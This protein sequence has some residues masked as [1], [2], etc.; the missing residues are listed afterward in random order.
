MVAAK[1]NDAPTAA[2]VAELF[3][4][5]DMTEEAITLY[6]KAIALAP[7]APQYREYLGEYYHTLKRSDDALKTWAE[8][9]SGPNRNAKNLSRLSEVLSGFGFL[10]PALKAAGEARELAPDD[11]NLRIKYAA[12]LHRA[13]RHAEALA[14]LDIADKLASDDDEFLAVVEQQIKNLMMLGQIGTASDQLKKELDAGQAASARRWVRLARYL[15]AAQRLPE[16]T[17][18]AR[19]ALEIDARSVPALATLA[20]TQENS[21]NLAASAETLRKLATIDR[22]A[23]TEYLTTITRLEARLGHRAEAL[24]AGRDLLAAAP[25]NPEHYEFFSDLC[26]QLGELEEGFRALQRAIRA[27]PG[28]PKILFT[29]AEALARQFRTEEAIELYWRAFDKAPD[30]DERLKAVNKLAELYLQD[31]QFDRM[32]A[33]LRRERSEPAQQRELAICLAQAY[34]A[35][36]DLGTARQELERLF[37]A[38]PKDTQLLEQLSKLSEEEGDFSTAAQYQRQLVEL[39]P[40]GLATD[41]LAQLYIQAGEIEEAQALWE[42]QTAGDHDLSRV[43]RALDGLLGHGKADAVLLITERLLRKHPDNW[44]L[45]YREGQA[46]AAKD[47]REAAAKRFRTLLN[48]NVEDDELGAIAKA[49][50]GRMGNQP[51]PANTAFQ[52]FMS[53]MVPMQSRVWASSQAAGVAGIGSRAGMASGSAWAPTDFGQARM[54]AIAFLFGFAQHENK[55]QEFV[56]K[57]REAGAKSGPDAR[58]RW[59]LFYLQMVRDRAREIFE[60]ARDLARGSPNDPSAQWAFLFYL[61]DRTTSPGRYNFRPTTIGEADHIPPLKEEDIDL[62]LSAYHTLSLHKPEWIRPEILVNVDIELRRAKR[63]DQ[64]EA[65]YREALARANDGPTLAS[66]LQLAAERGNVD[67]VL[68]LFDKADQRFVGYQ[69]Y[70]LYSSYAGEAE[71][72]AR[73]MNARAQVN[74]HEDIFKIC[75]H[76]LTVARHRDPM[77]RRR[78]TYGTNPFIYGPPRYMIWLGKNYRFKAI[79]FPSPNDYFDRDALTLLRTAFELCRRDGK[80][81]DLKAHLRQT[82]DQAHDDADRLYALLGLTYVQWWAEERD[83]AKKTMARACELI[84]SDPEL[85]LTQAELY[86]KRGEMSEALATADTVEPPDQKLMQRRE[87]MALRLAVRTGDVARARKAAERL[88]ALRLDSQVQIQLADQMHQLG[89]NELADAVLSKARRRAGGKVEALLDLMRQYQQQNNTDAALQIAHQILRRGPSSFTP[90]LDFEQMGRRE[91]IQVLARSGKLKDLI[92]RLEAQIKTTPGSVQLYRTLADY[93]RADNQRDKARAAD[94]KVIELRPDDGKLRFQVAQRFLEAGEAEASIEHFKIAIEKEPSLFVYS[95]NEI[96]SAYTQANKIDDLLTLLEQLDFKKLGY[97][98]PII[99]LVQKILR[100]PARK[101]RGLRL[102]QKAWDAFPGDRLTVI[103]LIRDDAVARL[104]E[105]YDYYRRAILPA[106]EETQVST[107]AGIDEWVYVDENGQLTGVL[108]RLIEAAERQGK[109]DLLGQDVA[110]AVKRVPSWVGGKGVLAVIQA[111]QGRFDEARRNFQALLNDEST[112]IP[113]NASEVLGFEIQDFGPLRP[114]VEELYRRAGQDAGPDRMIRNHPYLRLAKV[115]HRAGR[116]AEARALLLPF[117]DRDFDPIGNAGYAAYQKIDTLTLLGY[118]LLDF[119]FPADAAIMFAKILAATEVQ[120]QAREWAGNNSGGDPVRIAREGLAR[121]LVSLD[122]E[123]LGQSLQTM[124]TPSNQAE[125]PSL[126]LM[127]I[128][129]PREIDRAAVFSLFERALLRAPSDL[130]DEVRTALAKL[131]EQRPQDLSVA[132]ASTLL[133]LADEDRA[134]ITQAVDHLAR[135]VADRPV[136]DPAASPWEESRR[137]AADNARLALWIV[138]RRCWDQD[139]LKKAGEILA[140]QAL[141]VADCQD[142]P[143]FAFAMRREWGL[144]Q[145]RRGDREAAEATWAT[146]LD[147]ILAFGHAAKPAEPKKE[148]ADVPMTTPERFHQSAELA[149]LA[150]EHDMIDLALRAVRE[151]LHGG[152]PVRAII[153]DPDQRAYRGDEPAKDATTKDVQGDLAALDDD[154][155]QAGVAPETVYEAF[156]EIVLPATRPTEVFLYAA[157][158][159]SVD[160]KRPR[161]VGDLLARWAVRAGKVNDLKQWIE[162]RR[163]GNAAAELPSGVLL[164]QLGL[165]AHDTDLVNQALER[166]K[167]RLPKDSSQTSLELACHAA[168]PALLTDGSNSLALAVAETAAKGLTSDQNSEEPE[169]SLTATLARLRFAAG[170]VQEGQQWLDRYSQAMDHA[171]IRYGGDVETYRRKQNLARLARENLRSGRWAEAL[172]A[173]GKFADIPSPKQGDPPLGD[174]VAALGRF[175][176]SQPPAER[177]EKLKAWTLPD[178]NHKAVR[179]LASFVPEDAP[180]ELFGKFAQPSTADPFGGL[181]SMAGLLIDVARQTG[182]LGEL[183]EEVR[184]L[185]EAKTENAEIL[186]LLIE[187]ARSHGAEVASQLRAIQASLPKKVPPDTETQQT[188]I[189]WS[190]YLLAR[191]CLADDRLADL[192]EA[193]A[194]SLIAHARKARLRP[195]AAHLHRDLAESRARRSGSRSSLAGRDPGLAHWHPSSIQTARRH[196]EGEAPAWWVESEEHVMHASGAEDDFLVFDYPLTGT[197]EV[198]LEVT[199]ALG[200]EGHLAYGGLVF[201][202]MLSPT[203]KPPAPQPFRWIEYTMPT[204]PM[205]PAQVWPIGRHESVPRIARELRRDGFNR[206]TLQVEPGKAR[207]LIN[208]H[209][210]YEINQLAATSPWLALS[211][212]SGRQSVYREIQIQGAPTIPREVKL[213]QGNR[214]DG[215]SARFFEEIQPRR[216]RDS[217]P[218]LPEP[219]PE[220]GATG[221][222]ALRPPDEPD[223]Y[224]L[225]GEIRGR[226]NDPPLAVEAAQS[227]LTYLRP[228]LDMESITYEFFYDPGSVMTHPALG[229]LVFLLEPDGVRLH[230]ITDGPRHEWT[231]LRPDNVADDP[232]SRRGPNRLPLKAGEWNQ[233]KLALAGET[234]TIELNGVV[235]FEHALK[236]TIDHQFSFYHDQDRTSAQVRDVVLRGS[237]PATLTA[238]TLAHPLVP[239]AAKGDRSDRPARAAVFGEDILILNIANILRKARVLP[240][241]E[242][243]EALARWVLPNEDHEHFRLAG[244]ATPTDPAPPVAGKIPPG[245]PP[246]LKTGGDL[247][248]PVFDLI[249]TARELNRLDALACRVESIEPKTDDDR[250]ARLAVLALIRIAQAREDQAGALLTRLAQARKPG[251]SEEAGALTEPWPALM[252]ASQALERSKLRA[253]ALS[254][255]DPIAERLIDSSTSQQHW[256]KHVR[257]IWARG[258]DLAL[259]GSERAPFGT[260]PKSDLWSRVT[261]GSAATRGNGDPRPH[262]TIAEGEAHHFPGHALDALYF[263]VPLRD[264]FEVSCELSATKGRAMRLAYGGVAVGLKLDRAHCLITVLGQAASE[265]VI[266]PPLENV[267]ETVA[268]RLVVKDGIRSTYINGRKIHEQGVTA[269][270]DPWLAIECDALA[271]GVVR[272]LRI[273]GHPTIPDRI[274]LS[275]LSDLTGWRADEYGEMTSGDNPSWEKRGE[276]IHA[277]ATPETFGSGQESILRYH[278]PML[279]D[280]EIQ[281]EF[282]YNPRKVLVHPA[283]D[284]LAFLIGPEGVKVH[285]LTDAQFDRTG[286]APGN[287]SD[288][289]SMKRGSAPL[290]LRPRDW[291]R[292]ALMLKGDQVTIRLNDVIIAERRLEPTN[293][294]TFG[295]FR[296]ADQTEVRVRN[297]SYRGAWPQTLP[298]AQVLDEPLR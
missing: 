41:R 63:T 31:N 266:E 7:A 99:S 84:P 114:I 18:A 2:Q 170:N 276:E 196:A 89:M 259:G 222:N 117:A 191:A 36:G 257:H 71:P 96:E 242:R 1:P 187:I 107:W 201:E 134:A 239:R 254:L 241:A 20:R 158:L 77:T 105:M 286:L 153:I 202:P 6:K 226:R 215:W 124:L 166:I 211:T 258:H 291:N 221:A 78:R 106:P 125:G 122:G 207:Y 245:A 132:I 12:L 263:R 288:D 28:D 256:A 213:V 243:F 23:R 15:E 253:P 22:R 24:R 208:N 16:A 131:R 138:A 262:W 210:F 129:Q 290:P 145:L 203:T 35:S 39:A 237:W 252:V 205:E 195:F 168:L 44:D 38:N 59:E 8:M 130:R 148:G 62:V 108:P 151:T 90:Y 57:L 27:N 61:S 101:E 70:A 91:A 199:G 192:G 295:L 218:I 139:A 47:Q 247:E 72:L 66:L 277:R 231:G 164:A 265:E 4:Q 292:L 37:A 51:R 183:A 10:E 29:L 92:A 293:Q 219:D 160:T 190:D 32:I 80:L 118:T 150:A 251:F 200:T 11:Y 143:L 235:V 198:A 141:E 136:L 179:L 25:G 113:E 94:L 234:V 30:L 64:R 269:N 287:L 98:W 248:A 180:P 250:R 271:D 232:S 95:F 171:L 176:A 270:A 275:S 54:G 17:A 46:L 147:R 189:A 238:E 264:D 5:A 217:Q 140:A 112:P 85:R 68:N 167:E 268:Y 52:S 278:R 193:M 185:A 228:L 74:T 76:Y 81:N 298:R 116:D 162:A 204:I 279:E 86:E 133:A 53:K 159:A 240:A 184:K 255:L 214:L 115:L 246:R 194:S 87:C 127:L 83:E 229:R 154:L 110:E 79:D 260:D 188:A 282:Y 119:G 227:R 14:Q 144:D 172:G 165:A 233:A 100:D 49:N 273:E 267:G 43:L 283:L 152:P 186:R 181:I 156:R 111:R 82:L 209:L 220:S 55:E 40:S 175:L 45:L 174:V 69:N 121:S 126:D 285:W 137:K 128:V 21:G 73:T 296:Y 225:D 120:R 284:R 244:E 9:A 135:F 34:Q 103:G 75:D 104:S 157:P 19:K 281:Y 177:F 3:R 169:A 272:K 33:R 13:E 88:F 142:D 50:R 149:R 163:K 109:L 294:R 274:A 48:L 197:F 236:S 97:P 26:F 249:A 212:A 280:G 123:A 161:S 261:L 65:F 297:V 102:L 146:I 93:Y 56:A 223:W 230:W 178:A 182:Q 206:L 58:P 67:D 289:P 224:A 216:L 155:R 60:A 42:K 173:L